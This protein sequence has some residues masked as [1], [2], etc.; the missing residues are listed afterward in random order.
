VLISLARTASL[1]ANENKKMNSKLFCCEGGESKGVGKR[2][3][4]C[5]K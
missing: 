3:V 2:D 1:V 4:L 5:P